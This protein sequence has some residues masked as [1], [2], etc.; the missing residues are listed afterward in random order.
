MS[1]KISKNNWQKAYPKPLVEAVN[2]LA[3]KRDNRTT[4]TDTKNGVISF[5]IWLANDQDSPDINL[6]HSIFA[7]EQNKNIDKLIA[8]PIKHNRLFCKILN[9]WSKA[10]ES[11]MDPFIK[12]GSKSSNQTKYMRVWNACDGIE[13]LRKE[14]NFQFIPTLFKS[15]YIKK[16][17]SSSETSSEHNKS[18]GENDWIE[19]EGLKGFDRDRKAINIIRN[20]CIEIFDLYEKLHKF[21]QMLLH[22]KPLGPENDPESCEIIKQ[23]LF[24]YKQAITKTGTFKISKYRTQKLCRDI[25]TWQKASGIDIT[26]IH[27]DRN[28]FI[29]A[30]RSAFGPSFQAAYAALTILIC[31]TGWNVQPARDLTR[32]PYVFTSDKHS[33]L[34][35]QSIITAFK[36]RA[37][38]HVVGYLGEC[39]D[40]NDTK[41]KVAMNQLK[42]L[43]AE[44]DNNNPNSDD[45][46][47]YADLKKPNWGHRTSGANIIE[48][49]RIMAETMRSE[50]GSHSDAL[51]NDE[52]WIYVSTNLNPKPK[53]KHHQFGQYLFENTNHIIGRK[54][55][56]H[57]AIRK[58][59]LNLT[60]QDTN[61]FAETAA[62][63][64]HS[65]SGVLQPHYLNTPT[66]NAELDASI[67]LFQDAVEGI[68]TRDLDQKD[69][70]QKLGKTVRDLEHIRDVAHQSGISATVGLI[71]QTDYGS[72]EILRFDP[73]EQNLMVL[74]V[75]HKKLRQMQFNYPN[76]ARYRLN[77]LPLLALVKAIGKQLSEQGH[78]TNYIRSARKASKMLISGEISLP[79]LED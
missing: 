62:V 39:H 45:D 44:L 54:G 25:E 79:M 76:K 23:G 33:M 66:M 37:G 47:T 49:F 35:T 1:P 77:Y 15:E 24:D 71:K 31:D 72:P 50:F 43:I 53:P 3:F 26:Q 34:A 58:S 70:A 67:R 8:D 56:T 30:Y 68:L 48:R 38:H 73:T 55:F 29:L 12:K 21:G 52:F 78:M 75:T 28:L 64:G 22:N 61:S 27:S 17:Y 32:Y 14:Q 36:N 20:E 60:R 40:L 59:V 4:K 65:G 57:K 63:A 6:I 74:Y 10:I 69:I 2:G 18:L 51:F 11:D 13:K 7:E 41:A 9:K 19:L 5:L 46:H 42:Q 16:P